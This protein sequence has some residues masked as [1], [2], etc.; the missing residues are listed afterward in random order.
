MSRNVFQSSQASQPLRIAVLASGSGT[1]LKYLLDKI[2]A[3]K[4]K[5][6]VVAVFA[7]R[8]CEALNRGQGIVGL[9]RE[10]FDRKCLAK[11]ELDRALADAIEQSGADFVLLAGY[12][13]VIGPRVLSGRLSREGRILNVHPSLL[14]KYGGMGMYGIR[15]H[16]AVL[17]AG[18]PVSGC[19]LHRVSAEVDRGAILAQCKVEIRDCDSAEKIAEK[20]QGLEK[21]MLLEYLQEEIA[22]KIT[23][24]KV[25]LEEV[26]A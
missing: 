12:L 3:G 17:E 23:S 26:L 15:V 8:D 5:A 25:P 10:L 13:S 11:E 22:E 4:L 9:R 21:K 16:R 19:T 24:E 18:E 1:T 14:P 6:Q 2:E 20:V 7:D